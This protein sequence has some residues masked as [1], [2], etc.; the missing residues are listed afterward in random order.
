MIIRAPEKIDYAKYKGWHAV[1]LAG[2]IEMGAAELWQP[3]VGK[4]LSDSGEVV[5]FDPRRDEWD[6]SWV[7]SA[8]NDVFCEQVNWELDGIEHA[9]T[10]LFYFD[11][12]TKSPITLAELG[13]VCG[14]FDKSAVVICPDGFWRKG[15]VDVMCERY[16][17]DTAHSLEEAAEFILE[18]IRL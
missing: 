2:S 3:R 13:F 7:N 10:V 8:S 15:N 14:S 17:L 18:R 5:V 16:G 11:P 12:N 4:I 9:D 6:A 1:F